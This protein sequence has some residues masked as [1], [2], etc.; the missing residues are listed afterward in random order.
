MRI[1]D[2]HAHYNDAAFP[3]EELDTVLKNAFRTG[4]THIINA[5]TDIET[6]KE[7]VALAGKYAEIYAAVGIYPHE[8]IKVADKNTALDEL[9]SLLKHDKVVSLGEIGLDYHYDDTPK[10]MQKEFFDAQL[11]ISEE[12][13]IPVE[14][15]DREAH[16][17]TLDILKA[18]KSARGLMH[19]YSGSYETAKELIEISFIISISGPV[20][21]KNARQSVE[22]AEKIPLDFMTVETDSP[23]LSPVPKRGTR[24]DSSNLVFT[25]G[26][27]AELRNVPPERIAETTRR[28]ALSLFG[29]KE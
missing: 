23:Y 15:H 7:S 4:V 16:G 21:F 17:D 19:S 3:P 18:H 26:K 25:I 28:N 2:A 8:C 20:T 5:G 29:I 9:R 13:G 14:I 10:E 27:I 12:L 1:F 24:N 22:V 11:S 6:S